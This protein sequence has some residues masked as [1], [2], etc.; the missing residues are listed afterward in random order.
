MS[1][2]DRLQGLVDAGQDGAHIRVS[3]AQASMGSGNA[4][5]AIDHLEQAL[6]MEP[7]YTAA[8]KAYGRALAMERRDGE[9]REAYRR[10]IEV[11][12]ATGDR[13]A[14][15]EMQVFLRRLNK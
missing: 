6:K 7:N 13:Q 10:G 8:W 9:A 1:L 15:R 11:A 5:V 12:E 14:V 3:L 4:R 2:V